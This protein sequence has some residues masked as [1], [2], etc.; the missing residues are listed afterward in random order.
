MSQ[1]LGQQDQG[2]GGRVV[3]ANVPR[4][5]DRN[6]KPRGRTTV[7]VRDR[8]TL[9]W[10]AKWKGVTVAQVA[11]WWRAPDQAWIHPTGR[12]PR[13]SV[14]GDRMAAL[15]RLGVFSRGEMPTSKAIVYSVTAAGQNVAGVKASNPRWTWSQFHH[16][17]GVV[18]LALDLE[19]LGWEVVSE[20]EMR[21]E[22]KAKVADWQLVLPLSD[23][24][25]AR[26]H[27]PDLAIRPRGG[28]PSE[29][30]FASG[31]WQ[32]IELEISPKEL[33]RLDRILSAYAVRKVKVGYYTNDP[34]IARAVDKSRGRV[35]M[36][37]GLLEVKRVGVRTR[38]VAERSEES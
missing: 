11:R 21:L 15:A 36:P 33:P 35:G 23:Q 24:G 19:E 34:L 25:G 38:N 26:T 2:T 7:T 1:V 14:P 27:Y 18:N 5:T 17:H 37:D 4:G 12:S 8:E 30:G 3:G 13:S 32:A 6:G 10:A 22:S 31:R 16:E 20:R 28:D 9:R 29:R